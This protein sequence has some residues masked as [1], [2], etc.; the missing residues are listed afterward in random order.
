[1]SS[2]SAVPRLLAG[3]LGNRLPVTVD[4]VRRLLQ[5]GDDVGEL[6]LQVLVG[7]LVAGPR[8][9]VVAGAGRAVELLAPLLQVGGR[10]L[11][12]ARTRSASARR[13]AKLARR[14]SAGGTWSS[15]RSRAR[16]NAPGRRGAFPGPGR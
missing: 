8:R 12:G 4:G 6:L 11:Q 3:L 5:L 7:R 9:G 2:V 1:M 10:L 14:A 15:S 16:W 13:V